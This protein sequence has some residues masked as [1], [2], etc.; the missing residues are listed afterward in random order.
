MLVSRFR[1]L[2]APSAPTVRAASAVTPSAFWSCGA[3]RCYSTPRGRF[4]NLKPGKKKPVEVLEAERPPPHEQQQQQMGITGTS[5]AFP[6]YTRDEQVQ[7]TQWDSLSA[8]V[9]EHMRKVYGT[10]AVGIGIAAGASMFTMATP[11]IGVHPLIPGLGA[12]VPLM[13]IM[14]TSNH[15]TS[16]ALRAAMFAAFTGLSGM[17][18]APMLYMALKVSPAIVP[19]AL[20]ITTGLFGA[21]TGLSLVAKPG[22]MLRW[23]VPLT[24]GLFVLMACGIGSMFVPVTSAWYPLLHNIYLYGGLSLFTLYIAY[25]TQKMIDEYQMGEDDHLKHAVDLFIDFKIVFTRVLSLL[26]LSRDD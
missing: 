10:L 26:M 1:S 16:P 4:S 21:M 12:M 20:L 6:S 8:G 15:T 17:S 22:S 18:L 2:A 24:G 14:Y 7:G 11:L 19:Q 3:R 5:Q 23:G 25:D 13:G 9:V